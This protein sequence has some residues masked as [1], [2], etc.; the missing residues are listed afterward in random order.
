L[1][2][3][4]RVE[5]QPT[6][7]TQLHLVEYLAILIWRRQRPLAAENAIISRT[8]RFLGLA[9]RPV[10]ELPNQSLLR[11]VE[12][13]H[14]KRQG[15]EPEVILQAMRGLW[16]LADQIRTRQLDFS[17]DIETIYEIYGVVDVNSP[18]SFVQRFIALLIR[19]SVERS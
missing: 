5:W 8:P 1:H 14:P 16:R 2:Q 17:T 4:L 9:G 15:A 3:A 10:T 11:V 13:D 7:A 19:A 18:E 12:N 6:N